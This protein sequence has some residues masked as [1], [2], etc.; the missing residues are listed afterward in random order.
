MDVIYIGEVHDCDMCSRELTTVFYDAKT[1]QGPWGK[2]DERCF[3]I[4]GV[5]L[6]TGRGQKYELRELPD[7]GRAWVKVAG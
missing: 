3:R 2:L 4:Y 1:I 7:L 5:G 6:G